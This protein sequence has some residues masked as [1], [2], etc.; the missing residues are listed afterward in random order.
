MAANTAPIYSRVSDI[1]NGGL[2]NSTTIIGPSANT[3]TD[4]TGANMYAV[5]RSDATEGS[6]VQKV[7]FK[8][9]ATTAATVIRLWYCSDTS[10]PFVANTDNTAATTSMV[11]ELT[12]AA[13]T[14]SNTLASPQYEIPVNFAMPAGTYLLASFGTS[15]GAAGNGFCTLAIAGKY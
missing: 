2:Y 7:I 12:T 9:V 1:Q 6:F 15:T 4:G 8:A 11:A 10:S 14:A 13:W 3:A 5:F